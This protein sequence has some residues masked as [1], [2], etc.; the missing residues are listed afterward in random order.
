[1]L[2]VGLGRARPIAKVPGVAQQ[3]ASGEVG[4]GQGIGAT[5]AVAAGPAESRLRLL[6]DLYR[7]RRGRKAAV[8]IEDREPHRK[9]AGLRVKVAGRR[10]GGGRAIAK[11]P[12]VGV[13][14]AGGGPTKGHVQRRTTKGVRGGKESR[15]RG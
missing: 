5:A 4:K 15:R 7:L 2:R 13:A 14:R 8:S 11:L 1:M 10:P 3:A 6:E 12:E 9:I